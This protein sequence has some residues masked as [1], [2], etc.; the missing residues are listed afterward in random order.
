M[1]PRVGEESIVCASKTSV[2]RLCQN[3]FRGTPASKD[4][5]KIDLE[6]PLSSSRYACSERV[7]LN[8]CS[9][10]S[11]IKYCDKRTSPVVRGTFRRPAYQEEVT[12]EDRHSVRVAFLAFG[13]T[14]H[15]GKRVC[16][17]YAG[18]TLKH[19]GRKWKATG[20]KTVRVPHGRTS[21]EKGIR[22]NDPVDSV[23]REQSACARW[24]VAKCPRL[25]DFRDKRL[26]VSEERIVASECGIG[27]RTLITSENVYFSLKEG[28]YCVLAFVSDIFFVYVPSLSGLTTL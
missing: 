10:R 4:P 9:R 17:T 20:N 23:A 27:Q 24:N 3:L 21:V 12:K 26:G 13:R 8:S 5:S 19:D 22:E 14:E 6:I 1:S 11:S 25:P 15:V 28:I 7:L 18:R 2:C 16:R